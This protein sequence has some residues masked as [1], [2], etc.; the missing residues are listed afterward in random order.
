[1]LDELR[2]K[3]TKERV[4]KV[5]QLNTIAQRRNQSLAQMVIAWVL[6]HQQVC[7]ALLGASQLS[8]VEK[9]AGVLDKVEFSVDE[10]KVLIPI[11]PKCY[12]LSATYKGDGI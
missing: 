9:C 7:S 5:T 2:D 10:L 6:G 12:G 1:M 4:E 3:V 8:Q 11:L